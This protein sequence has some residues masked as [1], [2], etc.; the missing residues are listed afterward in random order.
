MVGRWVL[1]G[2][3]L[4]VCNTRQPT[5]WSADGQSWGG[6]VAAETVLA[7]HAETKCMKD[8]LASVVFSGTPASPMRALEDAGGLIAK[9]A[10][11]LESR[12]RMLL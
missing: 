3:G 4:W 2:S 8:G 10:A 11:E 6:C 7:L 5:P 12:E 9:Y 1:E